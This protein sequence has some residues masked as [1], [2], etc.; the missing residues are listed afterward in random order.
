M[1]TFS[2]N[3]GRQRAARKPRR[4]EIR[5]L[6][7]PLAGATLGQVLLMVAKAPGRCSRPGAGG[8]ARWGADRYRGTARRHPRYAPATGGAEMARRPTSAAK[9]AAPSES[10]TTVPKRPAVSTVA[11]VSAHAAAVVDDVQPCSHAAPVTGTPGTELALTGLRVMTSCGGFSPFSR[12]KSCCSASWFSVA[13]LMRKP[14]S[15]PVEYIACTSV[16]TFHS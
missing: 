9:A 12:A 14:F 16:T 7:V 1:K 3:A 5:Q 8:G 15:W 13:S 11:G 4:P 6:P 10:A 2:A